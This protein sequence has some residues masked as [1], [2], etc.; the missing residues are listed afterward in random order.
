MIRVDNGEEPKMN[1]I[2]TTALPQNCL[3]EDL[4]VT[5]AGCTHT[6]N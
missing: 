1:G 5:T 2:V 6:A 3:V 4:I